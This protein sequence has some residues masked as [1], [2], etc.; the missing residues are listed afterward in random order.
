MSPQIEPLLGYTPEEWALR[1][2]LANDGIHPDDRQRVEALA[3]GE[4]S[5]FRVLLPAAA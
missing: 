4:G 5:T 2:E 1:P 3:L